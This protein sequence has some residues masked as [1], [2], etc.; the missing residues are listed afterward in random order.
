[1][2][3]EAALLTRSPLNFSVD[4]Q[5]NAVIESPLKWMLVAIMLNS[6]S[7]S[8][9]SIVAKIPLSSG[10]LLQIQTQA[11]DVGYNATDECISFFAWYVV[12]DADSVQGCIKF[13]Y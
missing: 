1:M 6:F 9:P 4:A 5:V 7:P 12:E 11:R 2:K 10:T 8:I 13:N 3:N